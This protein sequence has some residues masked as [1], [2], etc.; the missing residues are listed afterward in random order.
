MSKIW[1]MKYPSV[2]MRNC[3]NNNKKGRELFIHI[4]GF[5]LCSLMETPVSMEQLT[6]LATVYTFTE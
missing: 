3:L 5:V 4:Y 2:Q 1:N 6:P